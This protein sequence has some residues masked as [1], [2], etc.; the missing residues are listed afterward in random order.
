M[1][2][3]IL[4]ITFILISFIIGVNAQELNCR[5]QVNSAKIPGSDK[6]C[7]YKHAAGDDRFHE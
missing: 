2:K 3:R 5:V 7:V 4:S 6:K 1:K